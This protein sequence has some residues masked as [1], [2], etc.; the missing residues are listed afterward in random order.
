MV[1]LSS[2]F[3]ITMLMQTGA[4]A[5]VAYILIAE[6]AY[7]SFALIAILVLAS[8]IIGGMTFS[9]GQL[10]YLVY[11][12]IYFSQYNKFFFFLNYIKNIIKYIYVIDIYIFF[13]F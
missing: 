4:A 6:G 12:S 3:I 9:T 2:L 5:A 13:F 11:V 7:L 1:A 10:K 8:V